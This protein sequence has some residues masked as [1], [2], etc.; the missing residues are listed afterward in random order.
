MVQGFTQS[1]Y[2]VAIS[3]SEKMVAVGGAFKSLYVYDVDSHQTTEF[4][5]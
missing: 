3:P 1:V 2:S 5:Y 4:I